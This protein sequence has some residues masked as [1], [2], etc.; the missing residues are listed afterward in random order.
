MVQGM[1][2]CARSRTR[3][4][5]PWSKSHGARVLHK[6]KP[7]KWLCV[8][9]R[10]LWSPK[11]ETHVRPGQ[12]WLLKFGKV[13]GSMSC[14][15]KEFILGPRKCEEYKGRRFYNGD[16]TLV[17]DVWLHRVDEDVSG[18]TFEEWDPSADTDET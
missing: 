11:E 6:A 8:Q 14:V 2:A 1:L 17:V 12:I 7:G 13:A 10:E 18:L 15:E 5:L 3:I 16:C 4:Q 9:A